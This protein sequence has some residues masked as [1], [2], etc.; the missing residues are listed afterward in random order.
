MEKAKIHANVQIGSNHSIGPCSIIG[1]PPRGKRPGELKTVIGKNATIRSHSV[2]YAGNVIGDGFET[3]HG[4]MLRENN[5]IGNDVSVGSHSVIERDCVIGDGV[6]MHSNVFIPEYT[7]IMDGAWIGP[8]AVLTNAE[9]PKSAQA[10]KFLQ[11]PVIESGAKIGA[12]AT[13]LPG[14]RIGSSSLVGAGSVVTHDVPPGTVV[15]GNPAKMT[16]KVSDLRYGNGEK[17][18]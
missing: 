13:V 1:E 5:R 8:N 11:G 3:G 12:N 17:P 4:I 6:R 15:V 7:K 10:K 2:I 16:K 14:V 9:F 18:Y